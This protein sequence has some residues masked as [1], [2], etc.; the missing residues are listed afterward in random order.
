MNNV[1][2]EFDLQEPLVWAIILGFIV[3]IVVIILTIIAIIDEQN[4][5]SGTPM[6]LG[7]LIIIAFAFFAAGIIN[8]SHYVI[9]KIDSFTEYE[10][11]NKNEDII[12][13]LQDNVFLVKVSSRERIN[14]KQ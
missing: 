14:Q 8:K 9:M 1:L 7:F 12:T 4:A 13:L 6:L 5:P 3:L 2:Y 10:N 11:I